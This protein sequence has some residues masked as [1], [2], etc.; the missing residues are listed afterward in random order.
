M[1][2]PHGTAGTGQWPSLIQA[3]SVCLPWVGAE[4]P[5]GRDAWLDFHSLSGG[6]VHW[7]RGWAQKFGLGVFNCSIFVFLAQRTEFRALR[8]LLKEVPDLD[9]EHY[10]S[11]WGFLHILV[12]ASSD[13][14]QVICINLADLPTAKGQQGYLNRILYLFEGIT[15]LDTVLNTANHQRNANQNSNEVF[16]RTG[17]NGHHQKVYKL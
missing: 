8:L 12:S 10:F 5:G 3:D 16:P 15:V 4:A 9:E 14:R 13:Q 1:L 2:E 11:S 7:S 17:Q 6:I